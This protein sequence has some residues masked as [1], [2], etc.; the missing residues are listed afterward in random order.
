MWVVRTGGVELDED[1]FVVTDHQTIE[2]G[3][4]HDLDRPLVALRLLCGLT[5]AAAID[6]HE[7]PL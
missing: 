4:H 5:T 3:S 6:Q 7:F 2:S 1:V